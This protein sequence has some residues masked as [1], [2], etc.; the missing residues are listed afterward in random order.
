MR[1]NFTRAAEELFITQPA[2]SKHIHEIEAFYKVKLFERKGT[3][4]KLTQA[5]QLLFHRAEELIKVHHSIEAELATV[6]KTVKGLLK[7]GASTT[8][9]NYF[10]PK[11]IASFKQ[12]FPEVKISLVA[13]NTES[14][15]HLL[16]EGKIDVGLV[17]GQSRRKNLK[18]VSLVNDQIVLCTRVDNPAA[19]VNSFSI[20]ELRK[21]PLVIRETGSGS[22]EVVITALKKCGLKVSE[23]N[24]DIE[25]EN[26]ESIKCYLQHS[27]AFAF[28]SAH[29]I[30]DHLKTGSLKQ[31]IV[32]GL[33]ID[34]C[35]YFVTQQ[36]ETGQLPQMLYKHMD[37]HNLKL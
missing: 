22:R 17:E 15:E 8:V 19:R 20:D 31:L 24:I 6:T 29:A 33:D 34:R 1:L 27:N 30:G 26:T 5:G 23:L 2:V 12:R 37:P 4:I 16:A 11:Y 7:I 28:L 3:T 14:I 32:Q 10:L 35:F 21:L 36:G 18:Y 13:H 25:L 9:A